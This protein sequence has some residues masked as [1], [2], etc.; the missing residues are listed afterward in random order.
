ML[1]GRK[2]LRLDVLLLKKG[3]V[4][5]RSQAADLIKLGRVSIDGSI[6]TKP[7]KLVEEDARVSILNE[8]T[9]VGRGGE[10]LEGA[11]RA[12]GIDFSGK[13]VCDIG[14]S[15]GGFTHFALLKGAS[16]VFAVDVGE[17]QL[18]E[19]LKKDPKVVPIEKFNA[20]YLTQEVLGERVDIV[21]CDVSFISL[22][23]MFPAIDRILKENGEAI[24][25]VKPQYELGKGVKQ[26]VSTHAQALMELFAC[27]Q[28][29]HLYPADL[30]GCELLGKDGQLEYFVHLKR[31]NANS[32]DAETV[33][34]IVE[35]SWN[36]LRGRGKA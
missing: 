22:K 36:R 29:N 8:R 35:A 16:K 27:A 20:R 23:L 17:N 31:K 15:T 5:S 33:S 6:C 3:F 11:W 21:L 9:Y 19:S 18:D 2:T 10:K 4:K 24:V 30:I 26:T 1:G 25:L 34:K 13:A 32:L 12:F 7:G 14:A 28:K